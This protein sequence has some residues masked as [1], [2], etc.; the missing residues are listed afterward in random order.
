MMDTHFHALASIG[1]WKRWLEQAPPGTRIDANMLVE[2]L[3]AILDA[4]PAIE[5]TPPDLSDGNSWTW[6]E[7]LWTVPAETRLGVAE[8][9]EALGRPK[10]F[11]YCRTG[12][13]AEDPIP[14]RKLDG[15]LVFT[16][17]ELRA[18]LRSREDVVVAGPME[19]TPAE[20]RLHAV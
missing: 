3:A 18:W 8:V 16:A 6:R 2:V 9:A 13:K 15:V 10:S 7:R 11:V 20:R 1:E 5:A 12:P 17:G 4:E 19:S 14:H